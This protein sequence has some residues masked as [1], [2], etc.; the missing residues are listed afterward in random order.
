MSQSNVDKTCASVRAGTPPLDSE[1]SY[2]LGYVLNLF[3]DPGHNLICSC[4]DWDL[5]QEDSGGNAAAPLLA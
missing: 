1:Y 5:G 4:Q 3:Y 2:T